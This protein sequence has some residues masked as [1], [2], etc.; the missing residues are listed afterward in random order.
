MNRL[1]SYFPKN[2]R[3]NFYLDTNGAS[4]ALHYRDTKDRSV[5]HWIVNSRNL[6]GRFNK[7]K[8]V[9][10]FIAFFAI[11]LAI[12]I[13]VF[14]GK[15]P[16]YG[17]PILWVLALGSVITTGLTEYFNKIA[18]DYEVRLNKSPENVRAK[19]L[20]YDSEIVQFGYI[21]DEFELG[22]V[23]MPRKVYNVANGWIS[24]QNR[25]DTAWVHA[26]LTKEESRALRQSLVTGLTL[27]KNYNTVP[28]SEMNLDSKS[29]QDVL[30]AFDKLGELISFYEQKEKDSRGS[31]LTGSLSSVDELVSSVVGKPEKYE[32]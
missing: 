30:V 25:M 8:R 16:G 10:L 26:I 6:Y 19:K 11:A 20:A 13:L 22:I 15:I 18:D 7:I 1:S 4:S 2:V 21:S 9:N 14:G 12:S 27:L 17:F 24:R 29:T 3:E 23:S 32:D 5:P 28:R 31:E